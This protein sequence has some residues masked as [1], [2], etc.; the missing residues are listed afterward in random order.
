[1]TKETE[2]S[3]SQ[4][5]GRQCRA[6]QLNLAIQKLSSFSNNSPNPN[7]NTLS[8]I[9]SLSLSDFV[10]H[11]YRQRSRYDAL[12]PTLS[13][14]A[15]PHQTHKAFFH[16]SRISTAEETSSLCLSDLQK[17]TLLAPIE[18]TPSFC[19]LDLEEKPVKEKPLWL[20]NPKEEF[21]FNW[22]PL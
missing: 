12:S 7:P 6:D 10:N 15:K 3:R 9:V 14:L 16:I 13:F 4:G 17:K 19:S 20:D 1:M 22:D 8:K 2:A 11:A 5:K 18:E 21:R